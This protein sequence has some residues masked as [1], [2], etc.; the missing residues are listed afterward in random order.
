MAR[1]GGNRSRLLL[2]ILLVTS[3][4]LITLDLHGS[5]VTK[6]SRSVTQTFLAPIQKGVADVFAPVG[7]FFSDV[8]NFPN[9]KNEIA[10]LQSE[11]ARL[12]SQTLVNKDIQGQLKQLKGVLDL[13]GRG[14][15]KVVLARVIGHGSATTFTQT[16]TIDAGSSDGITVDKTV[17]SEHGLVG[18]V[19]SVQSHS[20]IILL[21]SDPSFKVGV[22]IARS[23]S[24][25]VLSGTGGS[26]FTLQLLDPAGDIQKGDVLFT[27]GSDS[28]R[29]FIPGV[30][31]GQVSAV[32]HTT[33]TLT[34]TAT[35]KSYSDLGNIGVVS[36]VITAPT[37]APR[38]MIVPT[39]QPT[40][41]VYVTPT[42]T[43]SSSG[44]PSGSPSPT[45][46]PSKKATK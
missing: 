37:T 16:I 22:R 38:T 3:L 11:N 19:K 15:Y 32:D 26:N 4:F 10:A 29:P 44:T 1:G 2:V 25:G 17:V 46:S 21:M 31:V 6:G 12:K 5:G 39:P 40:V 14:G 34:Q 27:N 45:P 7:R 30:P 13:S 35:V 43:P 24:I 33:A 36:I 23:Q 41:I 28:N 42:P 18:V 20:S 8:K 9:A